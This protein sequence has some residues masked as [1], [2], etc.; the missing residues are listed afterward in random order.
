MI[1]YWILLS[2]PAWFALNSSRPVTVP[3]RNWPLYWKLMFVLLVLM[4]GLRHDVGGDWGNYLRELEFLPYESVQE[5]IVAGDPAYSLLNLLAVQSGYGMYV[6]NTV[7][8]VVFAWGLVAFCRIQPRAWLALTIAVPY[9]VIVVA[10]G[11]SRQGVAIGLGMLGL[12][13]LTE[14]KVLR[15]TI[16]I[17]LAAAF[18]K[19]A[20][21]LM[22]LA[23]L[24]ATKNRWLTIMWAVLLSGVMY[25]VFLQESVEHFE[26]NY[27][28]AEYESFGAA[29]RI[30]MNAVPA[31]LFLLWRKH[32]AMSMADRKFWTWIA[33]IALGFMVLLQV[34]PSSTAVDRV[35]LYII[36]LQLVV[37]SRLPEVLGRSSGSGNKGLVLSVIV[38]SFL[39]QFIWLFYAIHA[40]L[41]LPYQFYPWV[42][43][44]Q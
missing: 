22:P 4:I 21:I 18:H 42:L 3:D 37:L 7:C 15:F 9:L 23:A 29:I 13:A 11:Y 17:F 24:A 30:A 33:L 44:R 8:A 6:V 38:Y 20:V 40:Y 26:V 41:W 10:M 27:L 19:S 5:A 14:R 1:P 2:I 43:I 25:I 36:P 16:F 31:V 35:G 28:E 12:V 34:S 32:F 39:V